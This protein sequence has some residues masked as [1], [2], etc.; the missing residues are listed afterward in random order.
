MKNCVG[1]SSGEVS[2]NYFKLEKLLRLAGIIGTHRSCLRRYENSFLTNELMEYS[3]ENGLDGKNL[4]QTLLDHRTGRWYTP[5]DKFDVKKQRLYVLYDSRYTKALN[6]IAVT[7]LTKKDTI[8]EVN[9][10]IRLYLLKLYAKHVSKD[11]KVVDYK[12]MENSIEFRQFKTAIG[13]LIY[14]S[15]ENMSGSMKTAFFINIFNALVIHGQIVE[16]F[17]LNYWQRRMFFRKC[18]YI[19]ARQLYSLNDIL[20]GIL[21][22]NTK[23]PDDFRKPFSKKD[24]RIK[25]TLEKPEPLIHFALVYGTKS[26][27]QLRIYSPEAVCRGTTL[28]GGSQLFTSRRMYL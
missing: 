9:E 25:A 21:R 5:N 22:G 13:T 7:N 19:I 15:V 28:P 4:G 14:I 20:N 3:W 17:P 8:I 12:N 2:D 23:G 26:S 24:P 27:P 16:G 6:W 18:R 10:H 1:L 11:G